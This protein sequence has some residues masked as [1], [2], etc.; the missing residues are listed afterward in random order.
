MR[1]K[2]A[3]LSGIQPFRNQETN[4]APITKATTMELVYQHDKG[5][6]KLPLSLPKKK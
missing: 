5:E 6:L 1:R 2:S 3:P 4:A